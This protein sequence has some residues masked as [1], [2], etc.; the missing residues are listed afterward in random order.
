MEQLTFKVGLISLLALVVSWFFLFSQGE[1]SQVD[2]LNISAIIV[3]CSE[4]TNALTRFEGVINPKHILED[5]DLLKELRPLLVTSFSS[6][7]HL[8]DTD[9]KMKAAAANIAC[10]RNLPFLV[11]STLL[12][13]RSHISKEI[14]AF[15]TQ[16]ENNSHAFPIGRPT[17]TF[18]SRYL[19]IPSLFASLSS[20]GCDLYRRKLSPSHSIAMDLD[21]W[22]GR[23][24]TYLA[25]YHPRRIRTKPELP[26]QLS[27]R[28]AVVM[29]SNRIDLDS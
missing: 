12:A 17:R 10:V 29:L 21:T 5:Q 7:G 13:Q 3:V 27:I 9:S 18:L 6:L 4:A 8:I 16:D 22:V 1:I 24:S 11:M 19:H 28:A 23:S 2:A 14:L 20:V 15:A 25:P 26:L